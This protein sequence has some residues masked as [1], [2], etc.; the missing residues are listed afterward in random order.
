MT[1][2]KRGA[3][4]LPVEVANIDRFGVWLYVLGK[5][6]FIPYEGYPWFRQATIEQILNVEIEYDDQGPDLDVDLSV[7]SLENPGDFPLVYR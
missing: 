5:E 1:S 6:Y 2:S 4:T 7:E 3:P